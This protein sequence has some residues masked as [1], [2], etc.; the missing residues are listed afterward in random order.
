MTYFIGYLLVF[1]LLSLEGTRYLRE[2]T[3]RRGYIV[4][5]LFYFGAFFFMTKACVYVVSLT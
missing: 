4:P 3:T 1:T 5:M 2:T